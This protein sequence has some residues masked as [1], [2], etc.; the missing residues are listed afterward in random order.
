[1]HKAEGVVRSIGDELIIEH[2]AIP[3]LGT[4]AMTTPY[5]APIGGVPNDLK[6]GTNVRFE[7]VVTPQGDMQLTSIA[8]GGGGAK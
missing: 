4:G 1:M 5:K 8:P 6:A 7:F 3:S 2:G